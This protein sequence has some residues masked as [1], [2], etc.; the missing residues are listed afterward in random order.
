MFSLKLINLADKKLV[1]FK[2]E[3][4]SPPLLIIMGEKGILSCGYFSMEA[5]EKFNVAVAI[6]KGVETFEDMLKARVQDLSAA[7]EK[8]GIKK[9]DLGEKALSKL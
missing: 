4:V 2:I 5:A 8:L 9:G 3:S 6:V 7:A 1:G